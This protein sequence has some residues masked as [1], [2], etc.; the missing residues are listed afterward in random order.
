MLWN[1]ALA[2]SKRLSISLVFCAA[3]IAGERL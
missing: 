1:F 3:I 2:T